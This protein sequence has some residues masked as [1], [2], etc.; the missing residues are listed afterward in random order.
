[1]NRTYLKT[2]SYRTYKTQRST[3]A[4]S[5]TFLETALQLEGWRTYAMYRTY[6]KTGARWKAGEPIYFTVS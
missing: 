6:L 1:M 4:M 2:A 3:C 5:R